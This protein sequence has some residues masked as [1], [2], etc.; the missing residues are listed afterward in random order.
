[1]RLLISNSSS[2]KCKAGIAL[3]NEFIFAVDAKRVFRRPAVNAA[4]HRV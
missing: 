4:A 3:E 2:H 1:M